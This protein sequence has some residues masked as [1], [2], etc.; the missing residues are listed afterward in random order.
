MKASPPD[1]DDELQPDA[2]LRSALQHAPDGTSRPPPALRNAVSQAARASLP[3]RP[4]LWQRW[5]GIGPGHA[6]PPRL[7]TAV[8]GIS[9]L[10]LALNLAWH[11]SK[12]PDEFDPVAAAPE[13]KRAVGQEPPSA[14]MREEVAAAAPQPPTDAAPPP[15][16]VSPLQAP[17]TEPPAVLAQ[18]PTRHDAAP[19]PVVTTAAPPPAPAPVAAPAPL[20]PIVADA[21]SE[22]AAQPSGSADRREQDKLAEVSAPPPARERVEIAS[23]RVRLPTESRE[24]A[25]MAKAS[26][27]V[28]ADSAG[29][30][31]SGLASAAAKP[32]AEGLAR[33]KTAAAP[34]TPQAASSAAWPSPLLGFSNALNAADEWPA[35]WQQQGPAEVAPPRR[36]WWQAM[37]AATAGRWQAWSSPLPGAVEAGLTWRLHG[38]EGTSF[39]LTLADGQAWLQA[40]G[41]VWRAPWTVAPPR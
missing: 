11:L 19:A 13:A 41:A 9:A 3:P 15:R 14:P 18:A 28:A 5:F 7:W 27:G 23:S 30:E 29:N 24:L 6:G 1:G 2:R 26:P 36:A 12:A 25:P 17:R 31:A 34:A 40:G 16:A 21:K 20:A 33:G 4:S 8:A 35:G 22:A 38:P 32:A 39:S 10:G 37:L